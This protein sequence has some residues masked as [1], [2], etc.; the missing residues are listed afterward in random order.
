MPSLG[1][2]FVKNNII[3]VKFLDEIIEQVK[4]IPQK[5]L[6]TKKHVNLFMEVNHKSVENNNMLKS[7]LNK[8]EPDPQMETIKNL[9][10]VSK[11]LIEIRPKT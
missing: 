8:F 4:F 7:T 3:C 1:T 6:T 5:L 11:K 9:P 2:L 10:D